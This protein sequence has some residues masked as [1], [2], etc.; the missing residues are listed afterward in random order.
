MYQGM[1]AQAL[2]AA[3]YGWDASPVS[4][5][6]AAA[7]VWSVVKNDDWALVGGSFGGW[8]PRLWKVTEYYQTLGG[9]GSYGVGYTLPASIGAALANKNK[10]LLSISH[11]PDG[12]AMYGH[13]ALVT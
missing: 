11:Q 13:G 2:R 5:A 6:R 1:K 3:A 4:T 7:E 9:P 10:G 12:D 8:A